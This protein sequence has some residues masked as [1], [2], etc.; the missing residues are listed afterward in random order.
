MYEKFVFIALL[1]QFIYLHTEGALGK[2]LN[3]L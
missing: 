1:I 3:P 2:L